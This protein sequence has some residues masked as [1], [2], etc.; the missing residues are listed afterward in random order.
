M[1]GTLQ[2]V[3]NIL[4]SGVQN[5]GVPLYTYVILVFMCSSFFYMCMIPCAHSA[6]PHAY[7][8]LSSK[9][10]YYYIFFCSSH[11]KCRI[12]IQMYSAITRLLILAIQATHPWIVVTEEGGQLLLPLTF[13]LL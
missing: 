12:A 5:R 6:L 8:V 4:N 7:I 9:R 10:A 13:C 2:S 1:F 11:S 3:L